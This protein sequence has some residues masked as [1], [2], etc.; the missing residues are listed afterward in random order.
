MHK[1]LLWAVLALVPFAGIR[2]VC[3]DLPVEVSV[4]VEGQTEG[5]ACKELCARVKAQGS[6]TNCVLSGGGASLLLMESVAVL[7][8]R[9]PLPF[10]TVT[11]RF[12][13][14]LQDFYLAPLLARHSP[15]PKSQ[16]S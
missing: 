15:P 14:E 3:I 6:G 9:T 2:V 4:P 7:P 1:L 16:A 5:H 10:E 12:D 11:A 8:A 13:A